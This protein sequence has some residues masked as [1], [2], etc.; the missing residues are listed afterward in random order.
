MFMFTITLS[1][2]PLQTK[3]QGWV[4]SQYFYDN[5]SPYGNWVYYPGYGNVWLP[6]AGPGFR[7]YFSSGYWVYTDYGWMWA[8]DYSWGW[9]TFHYGSWTYDQYYGWMW[10]PVTTGL[11]HG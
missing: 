11:L 4:N 1:I 8:S 2:S 10:I 6:D 9:A 7:P 5:L 3:A